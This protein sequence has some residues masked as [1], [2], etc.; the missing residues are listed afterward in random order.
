MERPFDTRAWNQCLAGIMLD[1]LSYIHPERFRLPNNINTPRQHAVLNEILLSS[2]PGTLA[3]LTFSRY[4]AQ[5]VLLRYW[6][7]LPY[8]CMLVGAQLLKADLAWG[9]SLLRLPAKVRFFMTLPLL[10]GSDTTPE[11]VDENYPSL[12]R[13]GFSSST[14]EGLFFQVQ[15]AGLLRLLNWQKDAPEA[16]RGRLRLLFS[17]ELDRC[18][19][20]PRLPVQAAEL[21]LLSQAIQYAK[22]HPDHV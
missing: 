20:S 18:F 16:L 14:D 4:S 8:I 12:D 2:L 19:E 13:S 11:T 3:H 6:R 9:G 1:P 22:S 10:C 5:H 21:L 15:K 7:Q 17:P